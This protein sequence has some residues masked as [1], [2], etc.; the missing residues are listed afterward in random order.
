MK[1]F[2]K[3]GLQSQINRLCSFWVRLQIILAYGPYMQY[4][5]SYI[6]RASNKYFDNGTTVPSSFKLIKPVE[7]QSLATGPLSLLNPTKATVMR[8]QAHSTAPATGHG[9][10]NNY[11]VD[12]AISEEIS[13]LNLWTLTYLQ[14][15]SKMTRK[16]CVYCE[17]RT[18]EQNRTKDH[19]VPRCRLKQLNDAFINIIA[20]LNKY[21]CCR[22]CN[23]LKGDLSLLQFYKLIKASTLER[24]DKILHNLRRIIKVD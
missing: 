9:N 22:E 23:A 13:L 20:P 10:I 17:I 11:R 12:P 6:P 8:T 2:Q 7:W 21:W 24:K 3:S 15:S 19:L 1:D 16:K 4:I 14:K 18:T 5:W